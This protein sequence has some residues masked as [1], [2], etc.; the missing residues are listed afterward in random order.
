MQQTTQHSKE[1][2]ST[3]PLETPSPNTTLCTTS[4]Q[5]LHGP[6][7]GGGRSA[8]GGTSAFALALLSSLLPLSPASTST[9]SFLRPL[10]LVPLPRRSNA[11]FSLRSM[12]TKDF[13]S[14]TLHDVSVTLV[15]MDERDLR[16]ELC[17]QRLE[18]LFPVLMSC[19]TAAGREADH[20]AGIKLHVERCKRVATR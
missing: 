3:H 10:P 13:G 12:A 2:M 19:E 7:A 14:L 5:I 17:S 1:C 15:T 16:V 8:T 20:V 18:N 4:L 11:S 6:S 9:L